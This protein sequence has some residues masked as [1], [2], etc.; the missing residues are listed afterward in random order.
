LGPEAETVSNFRRKGPQDSA[1]N[2]ILLLSS[3]SVPL[4][5]FDCAIPKQNW[6]QE[7]R[8]VN[9]VS[10]IAPRKSTETPVKLAGPWEPAVQ[11]IVGFRHLQVDWDGL[12]AK[13]PPREL[14]ESAI[15][16]AYTF[17]ENGV[18]PADS[19]VATVAGAVAFEWQFRDGTF[20]EVEIDR[21]LH[22]ELMVI[23]P[24]RPA[25]HWTL[26]TDQ[27]PCSESLAGTPHG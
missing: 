27:V 12:G 16:L 1:T 10:G 3:W 22:A 4:A 21:P 9:G 7:T 25:N 15:G 23:E 24:G 26:P 19:V 6:L 18:A 8:A 17:L 14:L 20:A 11:R 5:V 2:G 13:A